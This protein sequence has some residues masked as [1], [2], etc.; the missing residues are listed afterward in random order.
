MPMAAGIPVVTT[1][2]PGN[3]AGDLVVEG[4][5]G[6]CCGLSAGELGEGILCWLDKGPE[7]RG[8]ITRTV[9]DFDWGRVTMQVEGYYSD[10]L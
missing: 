2:H 7:N 3:A 9:Q 1:D 10:L 5:N 4:V 6:L 8:L